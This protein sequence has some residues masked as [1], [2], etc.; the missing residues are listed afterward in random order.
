MTWPQRVALALGLVAAL[1]CHRA[2]RPPGEAVVSDTQAIAVVARREAETPT[3][4]ATFQLSVH[5]PDGSVE[6]TRGAV[7]VARPGRLRLQIFSFG[8]M[9]SYDY[10]VNGDRYRVRRPLDGVET[11]GSFDDPAQPETGGFGTDLRPLFLPAATSGAPSARDAGDHFVVAVPEPRGRREIEVSKRDGFVTREA[12]Y[13]DGAPR[14]V[15]DYADYRFVDGV[16]LPFVVD[17]T[18][19]EK[20]V[21]LTIRIAR[22]TRNQAVDPHLFEF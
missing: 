11:I 7:V 9:T 21:R 10:T 15:I 18:Y 14:I 20:T 5:R 12:L 3:M 19:P 6:G 1:G 17:V 4:T 13:Q 2:A 22:Y 16:A 8:V